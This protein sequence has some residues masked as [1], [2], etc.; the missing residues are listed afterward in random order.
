MGGIL[1]N[2][3]LLDTPHVPSTP[4]EIATANTIREEKT[5]TCVNLSLSD[6][7]KAY[8]GFL[9]PKASGVLGGHPDPEYVSAL[10]KQLPEQEDL[11]GLSLA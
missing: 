4:E 8:W 5:A 6:L 2:G 10:E 7:P 3:K 9:G 1:T 11:T